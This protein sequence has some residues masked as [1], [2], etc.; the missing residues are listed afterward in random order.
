MRL[1]DIVSRKNHFVQKQPPE[2][3]MKKGV[4]KNLSNSQEGNCASLFLTKFQAKA[5][6]VIKKQSLA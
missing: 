4:L 2:V 3:F 6:N 5:Y 1:F